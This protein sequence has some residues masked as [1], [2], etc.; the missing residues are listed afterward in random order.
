MA[1]GAIGLGA[2]IFGGILGGITGGKAQEWLRQALINQYNLSLGAYGG[3]MDYYLPHSQGQRDYAMRLLDPTTAH[4]NNWLY[5][6]TD[7]FAGRQGDIT[8]LFRDSGMYMTPEM[9]ATLAGMGGAAGGVGPTGQIAGQGFAGGG[10][11]PIYQQGFDRGFDILQGQGA[12]MGALAGVGTDLMGARGQNRFTTDLQ[13]MMAGAL[14]QGGM[15]QPLH[16]GM[17][18]AFALMAGGGMTPGLQNLGGFG[19]QGLMGTAGVGGLTPTGATGEAVALQALLEEGMTPATQA[20]AGRGL[21]LAQ[22]DAVLPIE[23]A[24]SAAGDIAAGKARGFM[25]QALRQA[26]ARDRTPGIVRSGLPDA[27]L[28]RFQD[29]A[30]RMVADAELSTMLSQQDLMLKQ[31]GLGADMSQRAK[32]LETDRIR[33]YGDIL[34]SME[35]VAA[36]RFGTSGG[37]LSDAERLALSRYGTGLKAIPTLQG[38]ATDIMG[39]LGGLGTT[40]MG[41]EISRMGL[42]ANMANM[43][44]GNQLSALNAIMGGHANQNQYALGLGRLALQAPQVSGNLYNQMFGNYLGAGQLGVNRANQMGNLWLQGDVNRMNQ[45]GQVQN[46]WN[47]AMNPYMNTGNNLINLAQTWANQ[48]GG[49]FRGAGSITGSPWGALGGR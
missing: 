43:F 31:M 38:S 40:A 7:E 49:T 21:E 33:A 2:N 20:L 5:P 19:T 34:R 18:A 11:T 23:K 30:A 28:A 14:A 48:A 37:M 8:Q 17:D 36:G 44:T 13:K 39:V 41:H 32:A 46:M 3:A 42:G 29:Q 25:R 24:M 26:E 4:L 45:M 1:A 27:S 12:P 35:N 22:R 9:Q 10:W 16:G 47:M 6:M 15:T